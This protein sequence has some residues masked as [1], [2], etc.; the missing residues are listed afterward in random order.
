M[1]AGAASGPSDADPVPEL[2]ARRTCENVRGDLQGPRRGRTASRSGSTSATTTAARVA[3]RRHRPGHRPAGDGHAW[4]R[5]RTGSWPSA[6]ASATSGSPRPIYPGVT[7]DGRRRSCRPTWPRPPP[8]PP[9]PATAPPRRRSST[10]PR[11]PSGPPPAARSAARSPSTCRPPRP[12][13]SPGCS[14]APSRRRCGDLHDVQHGP[15][16]R[17]AHLRRRQRAPTARPTRATEVAYTSPANAFRHR[18]FRPEGPAADRCKSFAVRPTLATHVRLRVL[19][20]PVHRQPA[21]RGR[22]GQ[23][24]AQQHRLRDQRARRDSAVAAEFQVF[25]S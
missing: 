12:S 13:W 6:R 18:P 23:R 24:P 25:S 20:Q 2:R 22:A 1:G 3:D 17:G 16:V 19:H 15:P 14:S 7:A 4:P 9:S 5:A 21:L 11:A 10:T 8:A